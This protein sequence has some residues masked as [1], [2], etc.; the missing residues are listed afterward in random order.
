M[1]LSGFFLETTMRS[2]SF[3]YGAHHHGLMLLSVIVSIFSS[4]MALQTASIAR[5]SERR[6]YQQVAVGTGAMA[7]GFGVWCTHFIGMLAYGLPANVTYSI[8]L[9]L[10]SMLPACGA[11]WLALRM[12]ALP[13]VTGRRLLGSGALVGL[14]I[15]AM[16]YI[17]MEAMQT[18]LV[19]RYEPFTFA[20]SILVAITLAILAVW[21][22]YRLKHTSLSAFRRLIISG[23][24]MGLAIAG[25]HYIGMLAVR[26]IG[27]PG[28]VWRQMTLSPVYVALILSF[29]AVTVTTMVVS[30]N[31]LL[32]SQELY[33]RMRESSS[34]LRATLDTAVDGIIT[35][36]S[37]G[38]IRD[39]NRSAQR[40]FGWSA[41]EVIGQNIKMLMPEPYQSAHDGYLHNYMTSGKPKIIGIG[42][43]VVGLRKDG[44]HMP[45]RLAVG[46]VDLPGELRFVGFVS[47]IS[48]RHAL[49]VSLRETA[50]RAEQAA[51]AKSTFLANMSHE[52]RT[53]MNSIIGFTELLLQT[54]L[55]STQRSHLN[56]V[57]QASKSLL[58][59]INDI[60]DTTKMEKGQLALEY[61]DFSMKSLAM[62]I[63]SSLRL[64]AQEKKLA[65]AIHYPDDMPDYF[66]GDSL[67][68]LQILTN[69]VGNAIK[70]TESGS[71]DVVFS[72]EQA[73]VVHVQVRDTG[74]GMT[75]QQVEAIF[76]P[77]AQA[78]ASISRR[79]GGTGLGTTIARQLAEQMDGRIEVESVLGHGST[80]HVRLPLQLGRR[81][82]ETNIHD[83]AHRH[84][85]PPLNILIAD[86]VPQN[87]ELLTLVLEQEG[88]TVEAAQD[89]NEAVELFSTSSFDVV[90]MDVH[91]PGLDGL[92]AARLM[93]QFER[94][95]GRRPT[96]IIA[97]TASVME[98][99]REAARQAGMDGFSI[100]PLDAL[101][102]FRELARVLGVNKSAP[103]QAEKPPTVLETPAVI[104]WDY[105]LSMWGSKE[106]LLAGLDRFLD[107]VSEQYP[108]PS[109]A[110]E[111]Y[112]RS[113][114][115]FSLHGLRGAAGNLALPALAD[116]AGRLEDGLRAGDEVDIGRL[117]L[118]K[119][120]LLEVRRCLTAETA[121]AV[122]QVMEPDD[123]AQEV[124]A[125]LL[126]AMRDLLEVMRGSE[127]DDDLLDIVCDSLKKTGE[128]R[129]VQELRVALDA[130]EFNEAIGV[131]ERL[132]A[133]YSASD[134]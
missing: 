19:V 106:K 15:S 22:R 134:T 26:F 40:L 89:G 30:L 127:L 92:E 129:C 81:L 27:E 3:V 95:Q 31:G 44:S 61:A 54:D 28:V 69:L 73:G 128:H 132:I 32:R 101:Q 23:A 9:T 82:E 63:E 104:D 64:A 122:V 78:D 24:V 48:D 121:A 1:A 77:F 87:L 17:G 46:R 107:T 42:R 126:Q 79:F 7:F 47:D 53:P 83:H 85:L 51:E 8:P 88:H 109:A 70:F 62:Q 38:L 14:G 29:F 20:L 111:E 75:P 115:I 133:R 43:E 58:R 96:P 123:G 6:L 25:M 66:R 50:K 74:I 97:L 36:D 68:V 131:L 34:R 103:E 120:Q 124:S 56:T 84:A 116:L 2:A 118:L 5:R 41:E 71:V 57:R 80:F 13:D 39:Y 55:T 86:D 65:F 10:F 98:E 114:L 52:I 49:E 112:D 117:E 11:A 113:R 102:L 18:N 12:L 67:R 33:R 119:S 16:H 110:G 93:R 4:T 91:M 21:V 45:M 94:K 130:F 99:D 100:K 72:Y 59:L 90:L 76:Q 37:K 35:I 108:L 125:G 105:G 60:L